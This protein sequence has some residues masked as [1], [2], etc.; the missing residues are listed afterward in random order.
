MGLVS[1]TVTVNDFPDDKLKAG[2]K[3]SIP[4]DEE[5]TM[6]NAHSGVERSGIIGERRARGV[7]TGLG[8]TLEAENLRLGQGRG[9][10]GSTYVRSSEVENDGVLGRG[11]DSVGGEHETTLTN[12]H[13]DLG[14]AHVVKDKN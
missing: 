3:A 6:R 8:D 7:E 13:R 9:T 4:G 12:R 11:G 14:L 1:L 5:V 2:Q 10:E